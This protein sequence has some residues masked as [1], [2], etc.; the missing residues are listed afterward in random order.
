MAFLLDFFV[1]LIIA[2]TVFTVV[3]KGFVRT[4][5]DFASVI[6]ALVVAK[7]FSSSVSLF[8]YDGLQKVVSG[9]IN[10]IIGKLIQD[11]NLPKNLESGELF[12]FLSKYNGDLADKVTVDVVENTADVITQYLVGILSYA[13]AFLL[14]FILT[15]IVFKVASFVLGGIFE[16][17]I[18]KTVNKTLA[19]ILAIVIS[20]VYVL[21]FTAFM[22]IIV[23]YL[24]SVYPDVI[25]SEIINKTVVFGYLYNFEWVK[26]LVN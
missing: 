6:C 4:V 24:S 18:L 19:F 21:L 7:M 17:P 5:I 9:K 14:L 16:L 15:V 13:L 11:N 23:P 22:Q 2:S 8:F 1:I 25:N 10:D 12:N 26:I 20:F 3:K